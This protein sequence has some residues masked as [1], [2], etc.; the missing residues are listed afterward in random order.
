MFTH[1]RYF[2][3]SSY[4]YFSESNVTSKYDIDLHYTIPAAKLALLSQSV[5]STVLDLSDRQVK[6]DHALLRRFC[7]KTGVYLRLV[8]DPHNQLKELN[9]ENN[10]ASVPITITG[11]G[12]KLL[13]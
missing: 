2:L 4:L 12:S 8:L 5:V 1:E 3:K 6:V 13:H 10:I 7:G 11:C 9:E